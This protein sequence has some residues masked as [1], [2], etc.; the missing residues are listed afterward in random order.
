MI[1]RSGEAQQLA[2]GVRAILME[3]W[4]PIG[5]GVPDD[6]YDAYMGPIATM[7]TDE[8]I[9]REQIADH[10]LQIA[11]DASGSASNVA[12]GSGATQPPALSLACVRNSDPTDAQQEE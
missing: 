2:D 11:D 8:S 4:D 10:L 6:E 5:C 7:L 12:S 3:E 9:T 1:A